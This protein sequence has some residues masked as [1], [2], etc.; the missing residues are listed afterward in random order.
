VPGLPYQAPRYEQVLLIGGRHQ[1]R[2]DLPGMAILL[3]KLACVVT[4]RNGGAPGG[5]DCHAGLEHAIFASRHQVVLSGGGDGFAEVEECLASDVVRDRSNKTL[6]RVGLIP[7]DLGLAEILY[8]L[9]LSRAAR[10]WTVEYLSL[11]PYL[12]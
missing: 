1:L 3:P 12:N 8:D 10:Q 7:E 4:G 2:V 11:R 9:G 6:G 5:E